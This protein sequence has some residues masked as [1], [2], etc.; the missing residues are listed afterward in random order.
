MRIRTIQELLAGSLNGTAV[1]AF[2]AHLKFKSLL[3]PMAGT[4]AI[5][6]SF[7][8]MCYITNLKE[9]LWLKDELFGRWSCL[10]L[11]LSLINDVVTYS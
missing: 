1:A 9:K 6:N 4:H 7:Y 5:Y 2:A 3:I 11:G 8:F 10:E